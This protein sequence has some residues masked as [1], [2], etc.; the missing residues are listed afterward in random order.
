ME[1]DTYLLAKLQIVLSKL[2]KP[3]FSCDLT[4][5]I[6]SVQA[7]LVYAFCVRD[8]VLRQRQ[9]ALLPASVIS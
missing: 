7:C 5:L 9:N 1:A 6:F 2:K 4:H 8:K 3:R